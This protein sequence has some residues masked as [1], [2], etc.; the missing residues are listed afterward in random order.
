M[1][2]EAYSKVTWHIVPLLMFAYAAAYLARVNI[3]L[4]KLQ[5]LGDLHLSEAVYGLGA[6]IFFIGYLIFEV[7]SN[8][9]L[10]RIG[11]RV[12]IA[13]IMFL[14]GIVSSCTMFVSSAWSFYLLRFLLGAA[15][16]GF[17]PGIVLYLTYWYPS[18]RRARTTALFMTSLPLSGLIGNPISGWILQSMEGWHGLAGWRWMFFLEGLPSI[19]IGVVVLFVLKDR[20]SDAPW[21]SGPE[22]ALLTERL[23][24]DA[25]ESEQV[26]SIRSTIS[27]GYIWLMTVIYFLLA[28]GLYGISFWL[29]TFVKAAGVTSVLKI[30][31]LTA[32]PFI[33]SAVCMLAVSHSSDRLR[34]RRWHIVL[35]SLAAAI[36][37]VVSIHAGHNLTVAIAALTIATM[38]VF[39]TIPL[40]W[41]LPTALLAGSGAAVGIALINSLGNVSGFV[42]QSLMGWLSTVT[43]S[44]H[45]S[46]YFLGASAIAA[47]LLVLAVPARMVNK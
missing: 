47:A 46:I 23:A 15:E 40:F 10:H 27:N 37:L 20:I 25:A 29:P 45:S 21:L 18:R 9:L 32:I 14:W 30:G 3:G 38:G 17:F 16:A 22:K 2:R 24:A 31:L 41:S 43:H 19:A 35:P 44:T 7:P 1:E 4:A 26:S 11:A 34:E 36:A 13:R 12:C 28:T 5:M 6:G 42:S 39:T 33:F 8:L